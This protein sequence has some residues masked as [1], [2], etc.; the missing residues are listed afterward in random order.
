MHG[1]ARLRSPG[2]Q[3]VAHRVPARIRRQQRRV[4]VQHPPPVAPTAPFEERP[5]QHRAETG[6]RHH[7]HASPAEHG[8]QLAAVAL[9]VEAPPRVAAPAH[10]VRTRHQ[11]RLDPCIGRD[12][13][14]AARPISTHQVHRQPDVE[15]CLEDGSGARDQY[16]QPHGAEP[17]RPALQ[18]R[19]TPAEVP[20]LPSSLAAVCA[21]PRTCRPRRLGHQVDLR[22]LRDPRVPVAPAGCHAA[23]AASPASA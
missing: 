9:P 18:Q 21:R 17:T 22:V 12:A 14:S 13:Q 11:H 16:R 3:S 5:V 2:I 4:G 7:V 10:P 6:H 8:G 23:H 1:A 20:A 19:G 15:H